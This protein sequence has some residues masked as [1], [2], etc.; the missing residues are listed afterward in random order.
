MQTEKERD[1]GQEPKGTEQQRAA[2]PGDERCA[3]QRA[4]VVK[5]MR[6]KTKH[7]GESA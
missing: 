5:D 4:R 2:N 7:R 1:R 6:Q 3:R